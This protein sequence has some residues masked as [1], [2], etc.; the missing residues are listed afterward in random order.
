MLR[1]FTRQHHRALTVQA[2]MDSQKPFPLKHSWGEVL[3]KV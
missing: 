3:K 1:G 2:A